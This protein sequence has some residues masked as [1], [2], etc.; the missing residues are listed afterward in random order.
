MVRGRGGSITHPMVVELLQKAIA[1]KGQSTVEKETGL[2]HSM[3]SRYKRGIGEPS[4]ATLEKL[5]G[6]FGK[7]VAWLRGSG[8]QRIKTHNKETLD[9]IRITITYEYSS[10]HA[11]NVLSVLQLDEEENYKL[12]D[13]LHDSF[14]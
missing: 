8:L 9:Y 3:I 7:S 12:A 13:L 6:Y 5:A 4:S 2:S 14:M 10:I 11:E 1:E